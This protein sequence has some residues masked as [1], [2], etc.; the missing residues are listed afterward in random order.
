[1]LASRREIANRLV[2]PPVF[3]GSVITK[4]LKRGNFGSVHSEG[5]L[6][7]FFG[8]AHSKGVNEEKRTVKSRDLKMEE[9]DSY[10]F[11]DDV[12]TDVVSD[13]ADV[14]G[15]DADAPDCDGA[16]VDRADVDC[17][18][19]DEARDGVTGEAAGWRRG[20]LRRWGMGSRTMRL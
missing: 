2:P 8:S 20:I 9:S 18:D 17:A 13:D 1:L 3:C 4:G 12:G 10:D 11:G 14:E 6:D 5:V 15:A 16:D 19:A 7:A